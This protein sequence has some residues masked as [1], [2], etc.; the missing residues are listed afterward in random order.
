[1]SRAIVV[2]LVLLACGAATPALANEF[3]NQDLG[4]MIA[5]RVKLQKRLEDINKNAQAEG[6]RE[7][8]CSTMASFIGNLKKTQTYMTTNKEFC[9]ISDDTLAQIAK[10]ISGATSTRR[11]V[12]V[13]QQAPAAAPGTPALPRPP[14]ELRLR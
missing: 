1:M 13:A 11:K 6:A 5:E 14:V 7:R 2:G 9:Q 10:G 12:C 8:F 3:C 4:P